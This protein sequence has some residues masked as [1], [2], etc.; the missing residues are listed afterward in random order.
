MADTQ[1]LNGQETLKGTTTPC[2]WNQKDKNPNQLLHVCLWFVFTV[3]FFHS[4]VASV[5]TACPTRVPQHANPC[6][7]ALCTTLTASPWLWSVQGPLTRWNKAQQCIGIVESQ[8]SGRS[9]ATLRWEG[10]WLVTCLAQAWRMGRCRLS[11][12]GEWESLSQAQWAA[13]ERGPNTRDPINVRDKF[14][15]LFST[16]KKKP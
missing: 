15:S 14:L 5:D 3:M 11:L 1:K 16:T 6:L 13:R 4:A 2:W 9:M 12:A 10:K 8:R 7:V